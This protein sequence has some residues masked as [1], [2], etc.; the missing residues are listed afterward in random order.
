MHKSRYQQKIEGLLAMADIQLDGTRDWDIQV[1]EPALF[2]RTIGQG[3]LGLG[4]SYMDGWWDCE[5]LSEFFC[6]ALSA[7]LAG[8]VITW[9]DRLVFLYSSIIN[10]QKGRHAFKVG[11]HHYDVGNDLYRRMLDAQMIY[12]CGFWQDAAD[13]DQAQTHKLELVCRKLKLQPGMRVLDI[14]CGWGG[15]ARYVAQKYDVEV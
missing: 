3:S 13:L 9:Q 2:G 4:E 1:H 12:S 15:A 7:D 6:R 10:R 14:G 8:K 11:E 5:D